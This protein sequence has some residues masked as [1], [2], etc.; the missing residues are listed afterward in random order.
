M[1]IVL[2]VARQAL[3]SF[4]FKTSCLLR[5]VQIV[6]TRQSAANQLAL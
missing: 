2:L 4:R 1:R 5:R 6:W 3:L